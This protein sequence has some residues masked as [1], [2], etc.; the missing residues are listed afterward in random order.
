M[1][2]NMN[3]HDYSQL[4][5]PQARISD[6]CKFLLPTEAWRCTVCFNQRPSSP[7]WTSTKCL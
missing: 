3:D 2:T 1:I 7:L 6:N 4:L 5:I